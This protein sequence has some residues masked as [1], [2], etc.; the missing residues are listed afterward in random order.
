MIKYPIPIKAQARKFD[1]GHLIQATKLIPNYEGDF[2]K[3]IQTHYD[4]LVGSSFFLNNSEQARH[5]LHGL[6]LETVL[7]NGI[8][9]ACETK[10]EIDFNVKLTSSKSDIDILVYPR[11]AILAKTSIRERGAQWKETIRAVQEEARWVDSLSKIKF[12]GITVRE[13]SHYSPQEA[14]D[15]VN[16]I[17]N[18]YSDIEI[19]SIY[20]ASSL[21][22]LISIIKE[23]V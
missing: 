10:A 11:F 20:D 1:F 5:Q 8:N 19:M 13:Y 4:A 3:Y 22:N 6:L 7:F 16:R 12:F 18:D 2:A 23:E 21:N 9:E 15:Y 14:I 17:H